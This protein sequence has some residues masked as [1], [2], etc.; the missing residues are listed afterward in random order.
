MKLFQLTKRDG[1]NLGQPM[2]GEQINE[3]LLAALEEIEQLKNPWISAED[4]FPKEGD[5]VLAAYN[6]ESDDL[7]QSVLLFDGC[8][9]RTEFNTKHEG[10]IKKWMPLP[11]LEE[12]E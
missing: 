1:S 2:T 4:E 3:T 10:I 8:E 11:K 9:F 6:L 12:E 7:L 5:E